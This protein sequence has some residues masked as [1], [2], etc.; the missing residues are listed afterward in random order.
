MLSGAIYNY[1]SQIPTL[2]AFERQA[3]SSGLHSSMLWALM[4][5]HGLSDDD[6]PEI[7][8]PEE[9]Q[10]VLRSQSMLKRE[11]LEALCRRFQLCPDLFDFFAVYATANT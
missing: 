7:G 3:M 4:D 5:Q 8:G 6:F 1:E 10:R 11:S 9:V 2:I